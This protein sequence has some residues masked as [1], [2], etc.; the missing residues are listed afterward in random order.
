M[1][2]KNSFIKLKFTGEVYPVND[3]ALNEVMLYMKNNADVNLILS[4][5]DFDL[6]EEMVVLNIQQIE[7]IITPERME[8]ISKTPLFEKLIFPEP[9]K[10]RVD[11]CD[12]HIPFMERKVYFLTRDKKEKLLQSLVESKMPLIS[13]PNA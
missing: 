9:K 8:K 11:N 6:K 5:K 13:T 2:Y 12:G 3:K 10:Y 7:S 1:K 4:M